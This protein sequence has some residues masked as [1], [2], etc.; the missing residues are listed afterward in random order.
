MFQLF[1]YELG[2]V[3]LS[4]KIHEKDKISMQMD[5]IEPLY[6]TTYHREGKNEVS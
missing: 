6:T 2:I 3:C 4:I 5:T 1:K